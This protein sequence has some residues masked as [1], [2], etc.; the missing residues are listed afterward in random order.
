MYTIVTMLW[1]DHKGVLQLDSLG[2]LVPLGAL[3]T[4]NKFIFSVHLLEIY[5][6]TQL[7]NTLI[8][9]TLGGTPGG[10]DGSLEPGGDKEAIPAQHCR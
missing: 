4:Q 7:V 1:D 9:S 8:Y 2:V 10:V 3:L 6:S 5:S